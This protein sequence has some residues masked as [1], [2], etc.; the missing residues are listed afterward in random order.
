MLPSLSPARLPV[1]ILLIGV[2]LVAAMLRGMIRRALAAV[3]VAL[4]AVAGVS[5][6]TPPLRR[7][8]LISCD[9]LRQASL[10]SYGNEGPVAT[11][12]L[13]SLV[14]EGVMFMR[15]TTPMGWTLPA[16]VAM[17]TGLSPG[18]VRAG[19]E[20]AIPEHVPL[21]AEHLADAGWT[22]AGFP[23]NNHWLEPRFGF[24][25]GMAQYRFQE[26]FAASSAWTRDWTFA[27]DAGTPLFLFFH[28]MDTHTVPLGF[29]YLLPYWTMRG[30]DRHYHGI[31]DPY[32]EIATTDDGRWDLAAYDPEFL[33]RTYHAAIYSLD[34]SH[35]APLLAELRARGLTRDTMLIVT[36][37]HGEEIGE[38]GGYLHDS[39][40]N[41]VRDVPLL[42][43]W[44]G[45]LPRGQ[46]V[47]TPVS[48][49]D[50]APTVLDYA[51]VTTDVPMHGLSLRPLMS[52]PAGFFPERDFLIDGHRR[53]LT[54]EP[55]AL[56][57]L[58][59]DTWWSL[60]AM[61]DTTGCAGTYA[62]ARTDTVL[63]LYNLDLDPRETTDVQHEH[64][65]VVA[66]LRARLD[67]ALADEARLAEVLHGDRDQA[68]V[69]MSAEERRKL[70]AL[71]Y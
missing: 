65:A 63:G 51:G 9:T 55:S 6:D 42:I 10:P 16:H 64:P 30:I 69:E 67:E 1:G 35:L 68:P 7:V 25:R 22:C 4:V 47:F 48:L 58:E 32:P 38:H 11:A 20:R 53:E 3:I 39:P 27:A 45:V 62:P 15:C 37:D 14:S 34:V 21:L 60:V 2:A 49:M 43:I 52:D 56:V 44:P 70:R 26:T 28:Y 5:A 54:L 33:R 17:F 40:Y 18:A 13:D 61:T 23:A 29:D 36:A 59:Q 57:A 46:F 8:I 24:D 71:G 50:L 41:E 66:A 12:T 31:L 19:V